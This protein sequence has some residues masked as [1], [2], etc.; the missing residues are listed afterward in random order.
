MKRT[1]LVSNPRERRAG[2]KR[3][4]VLRCDP[5]LQPR[6]FIPNQTPATTPYSTSIHA[7]CFVRVFKAFEMPRNPLGE[8]IFLS[9]PTKGGHHIRQVSGRPNETNPYP[10][11]VGIGVCGSPS[12]SSLAA[13]S[14][15]VGRMLHTLE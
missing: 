9:L 2:L 11:R 8:T 5:G 14:S 3:R 12:A 6:A 7:I 13:L 15:H 10:A 1:K 4:S